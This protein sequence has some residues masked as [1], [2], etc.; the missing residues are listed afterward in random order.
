MPPGRGTCATRFRAGET[1]TVKRIGAGAVAVIAEAAASSQQDSETQ[2]GWIA[3][4]ILSAAVVVLGIV[5]LVRG[6][7][8]A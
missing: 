5:W 6:P 1:T 7:K 3:F 4:G 2:W 8:R